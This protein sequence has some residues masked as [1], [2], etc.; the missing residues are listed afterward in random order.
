MSLR[1]Y[2]K[3]TRPG[4][5]ERRRERHERAHRPQ[6]GEPRRRHV[7]L[8]QE[9]AER[10]VQRPQRRGGGRER[11]AEPGV[12]G[13]RCDRGSV[14]V[15]AGGRELTAPQSRRVTGLRVRVT[16]E[17]RAGGGLHDRFP[18]RKRAAG[19]FF[20]DAGDVDWAVRR[21]P[22]RSSRSLA[23]NSAGGRIGTS[24]RPRRCWSPV[25]R[26]ARRLMARARR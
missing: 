4:D 11:V 14:A 18:A 20:G 6:L 16:S 1:A 26:N 10:P 13:A 21:W 12:A 17:R 24:R 15:G 25:T 9:L 8:E 3:Q 23:T 7:V 22:Q 19:D 5:R 2:S